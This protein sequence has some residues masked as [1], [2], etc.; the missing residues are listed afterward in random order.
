MFPMAPEVYRIERRAA[1]GRLLGWAVNED[2]LFV[3]YIAS[4]IL[5]SCCL[6]S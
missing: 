6:E 4:T 2:C 5:S 1:Q 3:V